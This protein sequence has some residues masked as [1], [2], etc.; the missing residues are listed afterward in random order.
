V[1]A[2]RPDIGVVSLVTVFGLFGVV[3]GIY[4]LVLAAQ[5]RKLDTRADQLLVSTH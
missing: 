5:T 1:L 3:I 2:I 4:G